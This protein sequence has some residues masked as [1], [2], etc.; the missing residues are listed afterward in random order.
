MFVDRYSPGSI[1]ILGVPV[2]VENLDRL[3]AAL[4]YA[5][6][7]ARVEYVLHHEVPEEVRF[8]VNPF[9]HGRLIVSR[10]AYRV[11]LHVPLIL[12]VPVGGDLDC[13][14]L[15]GAVAVGD[16]TVSS[17]VSKE[18]EYEVN[19]YLASAWRTG[20]ASIEEVK[21]LA[22]RYGDAGAIVEYL[23]RRNVDCEEL[24]QLARE[25]GRELK[26]VDHEVRG[27]VAVAKEAPPEGFG[28]SMAWLLTWIT[29]APVAVVKK[30]FPWK[31]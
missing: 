12:G 28:L 7:V 30:R 6:R 4:E 26:P 10:S 29:G 13:F 23:L 22:P 31:D 3:L 19:M 2:D 14:A 5:S 1:L 27:G 18:L 16:Y 20:F 25:Y 8:T 15:M 21:K 17:R 24:L 9:K 11:S